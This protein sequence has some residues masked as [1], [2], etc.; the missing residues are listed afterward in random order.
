[1]C[2]SGVGHA[3][4]HDFHARHRV[5]DGL[6]EVIAEVEREKEKGGGGEQGRGDVEMGVEDEQTGVEK[7]GEN[8]ERNVQREMWYDNSCC[9]CPFLAV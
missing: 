6:V 9:F 7:G 8:V 1:M 5:P 4:A 2:R 3:C